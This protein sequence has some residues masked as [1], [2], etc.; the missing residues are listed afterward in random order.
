[1]SNFDRIHIVTK[2]GF[3]MLWRFIVT[4]GLATHVSTK[5]DTLLNLCFREKETEILKEQIDKLTSAIMR[6]EEKA[7]D[8]EVKAK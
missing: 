1:M 6:E 3:C 8:L 5:V 2:I 7:K 4:S